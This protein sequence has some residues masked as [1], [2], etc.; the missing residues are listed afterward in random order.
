MRIA[1][2]AMSGIRVQDRELLA[3]G[4][5]LPGFVE[6]SKVI[7]SLPSLGLLT[8]AGLTPAHHD[9]TYCEARDLAEADALPAGCDLVAISSLTAQIREAYAV[10]DRLRATGTRVVL[11]GLHATACPDEA[12][13]HVDAVVVGEGETAWPQVLADAEAGRLG[14]VY[15]GG[16]FDLRDAPL[17]RFDLLDIARYNR[18]T[19]QTARGCP[20]RCEF[21]ASS[22]LLTDRYVQKPIGKVLA[23]IDRITAL[24]PRPFLEFA[25]DNSFVNRAYWRELLPELAKRHV[26]WFTETDIRVADDPDFLRLLRRSGCRQV[27]VGLESP[28]ASGLAG[29]ETKADWKHR[30]GADHVA[31]VRRI[32]AHGIRVNACF[33]LGLDGE[34]PGIVDALEATVRTMVPFDVQVTV[35]TPFPGTPLFA[36]LQRDG[37]LPDPAPWDRCTLF[38]VVFEPARGTA[39]ELRGNLLELVRRLYAPAAT[40]ARRTGWRHARDDRPDAG[41]PNATVGTVPARFPADR[42]GHRP[43]GDSPASTLASNRS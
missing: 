39:A 43:A 37:R 11:G 7:A 33:V 14:G 25:D 40:R 3:L 22:V 16:P 35:Q 17:P 15:R 18:L 9:V 41:R 42:P 8:L 2:L 26:R 32:Q 31:A 21:C 6:R 12:L 28:R 1:F 13:R 34:G 19:V 29:V 38:D 4:L 27:L 5:T 24:W 23:E 10:A 30:R 36:R 20:W